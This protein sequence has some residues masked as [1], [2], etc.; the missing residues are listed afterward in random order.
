MVP[1]A[2]IIENIIELRTEADE[3]RRLTSSL[4][5]SAL[6]ADLLAYARALEAHADSLELRFRRQVEAA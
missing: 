1:E 6:I 5:D 4:N 2:A 3:A